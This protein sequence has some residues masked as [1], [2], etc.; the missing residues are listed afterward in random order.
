MPALGRLKIANRD[1]KV[2]ASQDRACVGWDKD[3]RRI[4][5]GDRL[6]V[7]AMIA[8]STFTV[9]VAQRSDP[10]TGN[11]RDFPHGRGPQGD[12]IRIFNFVRPV[13]GGTD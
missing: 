2:Q 8:C 3:L 5:T 11:P 7:R 1:R 9:P 13:R 6:V 12:V 10:K 4:S